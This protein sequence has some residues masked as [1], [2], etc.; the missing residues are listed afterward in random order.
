MVYMIKFRKYPALKHSNKGGNLKGL[1]KFAWLILPVAVM[2]IAYACSDDS[3]GPPADQ[4]DFNDPAFL[5]MDD[6]VGTFAHNLNLGA[7]TFISEMV[8]SIYGSIEKKRLP[9]VLSRAAMEIDPI[10]ISYEIDGNW[11]VFTDSI[12]ILGTD[13]DDPD[14]IIY[15][16]TD[17]IRFMIGATPSMPPDF[18]NITAIN[19]HHN[20]I[21]VIYNEDG[22]IIE[23]DYISAYTISAASMESDT[24]ILD[25]T[26][27]LVGGGDIELDDVGTC[28]LGMDL[29]ITYDD[30]A[31][32]W[33]GDFP[34][35]F[36][37]TASA[38]VT[39]TLSCEATEGVP[40]LAGN[41]TATWVLGGGNVT[42]TYTHGDDQWIYT[43]EL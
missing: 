27:E 34:E 16:G 31:L 42:V 4:G 32:D 12:Q 36:E 41:W 1:R 30:M 15:S 28:T 17:S 38:T 14:S 22:S 21:F 35:P 19:L 8:D 33:S 2:L 20:G 25:G 29:T 23:L 40:E 18:D 37:G 13:V 9:F 3:S 7:F 10:D 6:I 26:A 43:D 24:I 5:M 39:F 11:F